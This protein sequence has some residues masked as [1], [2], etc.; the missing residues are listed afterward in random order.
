MILLD[1][2]GVPDGGSVEAPSLVKSHGTYVLFFSSGCYI[3]PNYTVNYATAHLIKGPYQRAAHPLFATDDL[4]L[5]APGGM[6]I[7]LDA[8]HMVFHASYGAGR[9]LYNAVVTIKGGMV[10]A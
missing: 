4:G 5:T 8:K 2:N 10:T 7:Y 9:A 1:N 6:S 3:T